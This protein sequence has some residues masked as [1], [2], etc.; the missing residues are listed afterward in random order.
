MTDIIRPD[1]IISGE[2]V[3][4]FIDKLN[5]SETLIIT[6]GIIILLLIV[7][8][9]WIFDRLG[10]KEKACTKLDIY[11]PNLTN[12]S[13]FNNENNIKVSAKS[14]FGIDN[15]NSTLINYHVKSAYNCCCG[16]GYKNNFVALC[17]LE[18]CISNGCRFLDF[19]IY[20]Y[21]NEPI[22]ASSTANSN[23][24]KET[25]NALLLSEVLTTISES[26]FD[27]VK[28]T[29]A[30]DPLILNFRVMSTNISMLEKMG[31]LFEEYF[32]RS[33]N[34]NFTLLK[35]Y[36]DAAVLSIHMSRLFRKIIIICD[37]NPEPNIIINPKLAKLENY[38]NMKGK[39]LYC[40]TFRYNDIVA[41]N[42]NPQFIEDTKQKFTIILPNLDNSIKNFDSINSFVNGCQA[43][44]MKHQTLDSNLI[45][46]NYQF[47]VK[48]YSWMLKELILINV[49]PRGLAPRIGASLGSYSSQSIIGRITSRFAPPTPADDATG[50]QEGHEY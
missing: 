49:A 42:G 28:T 21:N 34:S 1:K 18:K 3:K 40:N 31:D 15:S 46:Y 39:S 4:T 47:E 5:K 41:K 32:D 10:L 19:E 30:N 20:S 6:L 13:Y 38:I 25:Y 33:I 35:T 17:A 8:F 16:D 37:F 50:V 11:Y 45:G 48:G 27:G 12:V 22:V 23:Y 43:I 24:I 7:L 44:C 14:I 26:A 2:N 9:G 29:C 36:K